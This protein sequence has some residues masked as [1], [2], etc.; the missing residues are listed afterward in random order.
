MVELYCK[1]TIGYN[2]R[3]TAWDWYAGRAGEMSLQIWR[4]CESSATCYAL[5]CENTVTAEAG[6]GHLDVPP[7]DRCIA[8]AQDVIGAKGAQLGL[9]STLVLSQLGGFG[10]QLFQ[11]LPVRFY[12]G[13]KR[14]HCSVRPLFT[15]CWRSILVLTTQSSVRGYSRFHHVRDGQRWI[16][17]LV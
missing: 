11:A 12:P 10:D 2:P 5:V 16:D 9:D 13:T 1:V 4:P 8:N 17:K 3:L 6:A 15:H 7:A 14:L